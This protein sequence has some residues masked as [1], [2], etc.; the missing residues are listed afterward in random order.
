MTAESQETDGQLLGAFVRRQDQTAFTRVIGRHER[1]VFA[2]CHS[3]LPDRE[4]A[5]DAAQAVFMVLARKAG[6]LTKNE[7]VAAW[8]EMS[9]EG[10]DV[11]GTRGG[12]PVT[13]C[14]ALP[15]SGRRLWMS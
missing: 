14:Q 7:S 13:D 10:E 12:V 3:L 1:M 4:D 6:T 2:V 11:A 8:L 5:R 15:G 9:A